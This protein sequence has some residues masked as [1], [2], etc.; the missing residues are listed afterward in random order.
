MFIYLDNLKE[1]KALET[2]P[3]MGTQVMRV[4]LQTRITFPQSQ[5]GWLR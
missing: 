5:Q 1:K 2:Y 4:P 3:K